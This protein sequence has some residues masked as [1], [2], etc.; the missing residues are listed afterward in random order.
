MQRPLLKIFLILTMYIIVVLSVIYLGDI[1]PE[2]YSIKTQHIIEY[3]QQNGW[4]VSGCIPKESAESGYYLSHPPFAYYT[5]YFFQKILGFKS[6]YVLNGLLVA[7]SGFFVYLT[8]CLLSLKKASREFSV[9][10]LLGMLIYLTAYPILRF[11]FF[12]YHPDIFVVPFLIISQY[13]FLK[14]LMKERYRS[15]KYLLLIGLLLFILNYSSWF[16]LVFSLIILLLAIFNLRKRYKLFPYILLVGFITAF[17]CFFIFSQYAVMGGWKNVIFYFKDTYL[18]ESPLYGHLRQTAWQIIIQ[19]I[20]NLGIL[21]LAL[22][23]IFGYSIFAKRRKFLFTKNGY[24]YLILS[25]VP[26]FLYSVLLIQYFQN[27]FTALYFVAPLS[28]CISIWL[29]KN[30]KDR[31]TY[32]FLAKIVLIIVLTN[33]SLFIKL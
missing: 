24:R 27:T 29:E 15:V 33:L 5:L 18:R 28:V 20:K 9:F 30:F 14:L 10:A 19:V 21:L 4:L 25:L 8:I 12:N 26:I 3:W 13:L 7:L 32:S 22:F 11:Q 23:L 31:A 6:Y 16:G 17:V 2:S 1:Q